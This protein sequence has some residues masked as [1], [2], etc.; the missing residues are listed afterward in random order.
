VNK[1]KFFLILLSV[2]FISANGQTSQNAEKATLIKAP[3]G[4]AVLMATISNPAV[5]EASGLAVSSKNKN[6]LWTINDGGNSPVLYG[7]SLESNM[8]YPF[9]IKNVLN[10]DWEDLASFRLKKKQHLIIADVGDNYAQR[11]SYTLYVVKEP[12]INIHTKTKGNTMKL[13]WQTRFLYPDGPRDCE[14]VAVDLRHK[15]IL[16]L[17]KRT[18]PPILYE[19]PLKKTPSKSIYVA[20]PIAKLTRIPPPTKEDLKETYGEVYSQPTSMDLSLDGRVLIFL[21]YKHAYYYQR[22]ANQTWKDVFTEPPRLIP[23]PHP[24]REILVQRESLCI[25]HK[26]KELYVSHEGTPISIYCIKPLPP[27]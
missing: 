26:T 1:K 20:K 11:K 17:S 7:M 18:K 19:L 4:E 3:Y 25:N 2:S 10:K 16:L 15:R 13:V 21:T 8:V 12:R 27:L 5:T 22:K 24:N 23:L 6:I 9:N 14:A